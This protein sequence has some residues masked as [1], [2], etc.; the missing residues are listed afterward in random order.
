MISNTTFHPNTRLLPPLLPLGVSPLSSGVGI[1][2]YGRFGFD[3]GS[4][5]TLVDLKK[6]RRLALKRWMDAGWSRG[7]VYLFGQAS[8]YISSAVMG[9]W[10]AGICDCTDIFWMMPSSP[11]LYNWTYLCPITIT[12][13]LW[14]RPHQW[15]IHGYTICPRPPL[16]TDPCLSAYLSW[17]S[18]YST[19]LFM[20]TND[21]SLRNSHSPHVVLIIPYFINKHK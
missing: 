20:S 3:V 14:V 8:A 6:R 10:C 13:Q 16:S 11:T 5:V 18:L 15:E 1:C 4:G 12:I 2:G 9:K 7:C 21:H 17:W 19:A